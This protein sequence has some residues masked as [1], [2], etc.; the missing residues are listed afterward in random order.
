V[1]QTQNA[2]MKLHIKMAR[3]AKALSAWA[4]KLIP[5]GKLTMIIYREVIAQLD[6]VQ[7]N[8]SLTDDEIQ[9]KKLL[10]KKDLGVGYHRTVESVTTV[11]TYL[12]YERRC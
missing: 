8:R 5:L 4:C 6:N 3:T 2:M 9:F 7:E 12:D 10:K 11:K 1:L